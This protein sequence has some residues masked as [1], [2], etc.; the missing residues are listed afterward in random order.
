MKEKVSHIQPKIVPSIALTVDVGRI[1]A[2]ISLMLEAGTSVV[3]TSL[4]TE[5]G[6]SVTSTPLTMEAGRSVANK[7]F[8]IGRLHDRG[9]AG[10]SS[11]FQRKPMAATHLSRLVDPST[12]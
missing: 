11:V 8:G 2:S 6:R 3:N 5:D 12:V 1:V 10:Q 9:I 4:T 7:S